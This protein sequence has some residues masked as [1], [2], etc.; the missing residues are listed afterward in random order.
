[1]RRWRKPLIVFTPKSL[2]RHPRTVSSLE[3]C[4]D[5]RYARVLPDEEVA[6]GDVDRVLLCSGKVYY[7]LYAARQE[8]ERGDVAIVRLEQFY[9]FPESQL[10]TL[11]EPYGPDRPVYWIQEEPENMGAWAFLRFHFGDRLLGRHPL[12]GIYRPASASPATGSH[13]AHRIEQEEL[14]RKAFGEVS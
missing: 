5:G 6:A 9:P 4:A 13:S 11:L 2:L 3:D 8:R 1:V 14:M 7:D 10:A 12:T